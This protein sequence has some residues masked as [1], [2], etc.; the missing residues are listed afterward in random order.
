MESGLWVKG[1]ALK[2]MFWESNG[3]RW[4]WRFGDSR[5]E[6]FLRVLRG[7]RLVKLEFGI[8]R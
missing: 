5:V 2:V 3:M 6:V 8:W 4:R 1:W 7:L